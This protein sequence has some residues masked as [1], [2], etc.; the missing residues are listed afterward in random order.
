MRRDIQ[1][2]E[3]GSI[4]YLPGLTSEQKKDQLSRISYRDYLLTIANV[5][6]A[7]IPFYQTATQGEWG[8]GVDA[9]SALDPFDLE[10]SLRQTVFVCAGQLTTADRVRGL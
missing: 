2:I 3:T 4:D 7:A 5:D 10:A 1:R 6:P 8:V 9:V